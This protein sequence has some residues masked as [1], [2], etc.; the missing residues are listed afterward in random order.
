MAAVEGGVAGVVLT[1]Y[2]KGHFGIVL[3]VAS[4]IVAVEPT[5]IGVVIAAIAVV[6]EPLPDRDQNIKQVAHRGFSHTLGFALLVAT[7]TGG[8][9][10]AVAHIALT[11]FPALSSTT[12]GVVFAPA[13][14]GGVIA[15][16]TFLGILSHLAGDVIT[17]GTGDYG[18]QPLWPL[19]RWEVPIGLCRADST[20]GNYMLLAGGLIV[21]VGAGYIVV[22]GL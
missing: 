17:V 15:A 2:R 8:T 19:S 12:F 20:L 21:T 13:R 7:V 4:L 11:Q 10:A 16:G 14:V 9:A 3:A 1:M 18:V 6:V 5:P 22:S